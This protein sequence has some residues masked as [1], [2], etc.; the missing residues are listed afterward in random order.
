MQLTM[1][2]MEAAVIAAALALCV[3]PA[4]A[5]LTPASPTLLRR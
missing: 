5:M 2:K 1:K 3:A 4:V